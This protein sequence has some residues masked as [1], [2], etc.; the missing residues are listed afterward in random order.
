MK[1]IAIGLVLLAVLAVPLH[2]AE[3]KEED[4]LLLQEWK[5]KQR[6]NADIE[7]QYKRTLQQINKQPAAG[8]PNDPWASMRGSDAPKPGR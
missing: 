4:N 3:Q 7:K 2:A 5:T 8:A 1:R 6:D